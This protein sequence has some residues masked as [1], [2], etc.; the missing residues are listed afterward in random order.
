MAKTNTINSDTWANQP[1]IINMLVTMVV[2]VAGLGYLMIAMTTQ[3]MLWFVPWFTA[4]PSAI[5]LNCYGVQT[6]IDPASA[7][8]QA[9]IAAFNAQMS[10]GQKRWDQTSLSDDSLAYFETSDAMV[11]LEF[12]YSPAVR[13]H[14][15]F[16]YFQAADRMLVSLDGR[17][18]TL[19]PVFGR[20]NGQMIPGA[21][22]L[23]TTDPLKDVL[24]D[25]GLCAVR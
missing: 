7:D 23:P 3:D 11:M 4:Q 22:S 17:H 9:L 14:G 10:S 18:A 13:V 8:G 20:N 25:S 15:A 12:N 16:I 21:L 19:N 24:R 2:G 1:S 6:T 5:H